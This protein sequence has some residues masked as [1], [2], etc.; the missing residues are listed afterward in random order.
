MVLQSPGVVLLGGLSCLLMIGLS[1]LLTDPGQVEQEPVPALV[2]PA[3]AGDLTESVPGTA[4]S[5]Q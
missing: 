3:T 5:G 1:P 2:G 4:K